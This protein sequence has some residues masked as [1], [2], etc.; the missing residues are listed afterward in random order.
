MLNRR[1]ALVISLLISLVVASIA[2][3]IVNS[4][5]AQQKQSI[6][7]Q[8]KKAIMEQQANMVAVIVAKQD[9]PRGIEI[10]ASM[11]DT[12]V[13]PRQYLQPQSVSSLDRI[14][15]MI[16]LAPIANGEQIILT[17]LAY[18]KQALGGLAEVTPIG[19]RAIT[20]SVDEIA[21]VARMV[22]PGDYVDIIAYIPLPVQAAKGQQATQETMLPVLQNVLV[23]AVGQQINAPTGEEGQGR[24]SEKRVNEMS[25]PL[26]TIA[27]D[28]SEASILAFLQEQSKIRLILRSPADS[29]IQP[30]KP[31]SWDAVLQYLIPRLESYQ[32]PVEKEDARPEKYIE[33]YRGLSRDKIPLSEER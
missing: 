6:E 1:I 21:S 32:K 14:S 27:L 25:S 8:A 11:F 28:P 4:Y 10:N 31:V 33:I 30:I 12:T 19:K 26:L 24:S 22:K 9:I 7:T 16:T 17:K 15:G 29:K 18:S 2:L 23:L 5:V 20:I 3:V 13:I